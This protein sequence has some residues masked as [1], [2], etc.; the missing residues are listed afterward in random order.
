M[1][2]SIMVFAWLVLGEDGT[3]I[4]KFFVHSSTQL[5]GCYDFVDKKSA[6]ETVESNLITVG[7]NQTL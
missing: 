1:L 6:V 3:I 5:A 2:Q 4:L 7:S